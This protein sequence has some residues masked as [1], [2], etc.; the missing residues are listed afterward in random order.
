MGE[1][2]LTGI[3]PAFHPRLKLFLSADIVGSTAYKQP[4]DILRDDPLAHARWAGII[5]GFYKTIRESFLEHFRQASNR[6]LSEHGRE[7]QRTLLGDEPRFWKTIGDEVV[8]WKELNSSVQ[9]WLTLACWMKTVESLRNYFIDVAAGDPASQLDVKS[10]AWMAGFPVRNKAIVD[11]SSSDMP[12]DALAAHLN[13]FYEG[14]EGLD[15]DFIGPGIDVGFRVTGLASARKLSVSLDVAYTLARTHN[16]VMDGL[17]ERLSAVDYFPL[18]DGSTH[19]D[20][21]ERLRV[22]Y[23]GSET[24]RGVLGG[25]RYPKFWISMV[26]HGSLEEAKVALYT[27]EAGQGVSWAKLLSF[28]DLFYSD[29]RK[30]VSRP[31]I[32]NDPHL[33]DIPPRFRNFLVAADPKASDSVENLAALNI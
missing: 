29:R 11:L 21:V 28:C 32:R 26:R 8:F 33:N 27:R 10:A 3:D 25:V 15:A 17:K 12:D 2:D 7:A 30:Y 23:S 19:S 18:R 6:L 16:H 13:A 14:A 4:L 20:F 5:Q 9:V 31:F 1:L 24:L 22:Y